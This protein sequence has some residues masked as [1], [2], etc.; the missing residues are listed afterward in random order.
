MFYSIKIIQQSTN[1][2][3]DDANVMQ[4]QYNSMQKEK[5]NININTKKT[6]S[7]EREKESE[8]AERDSH[9]LLSDEEKAICKQKS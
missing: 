6:L 4:M 8:P 5:E 1:A 3:Q 7:K 2:E 9:A